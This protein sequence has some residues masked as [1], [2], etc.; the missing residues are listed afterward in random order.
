MLPISRFGRYG[1]L[2]PDD[3][4]NSQPFMSALRLLQEQGGLAPVQPSNVRNSSAFPSES[5]ASTPPPP[6]PSV[7]IGWAPTPS[8]R[9]SPTPSTFTEIPLEELEALRALIP[10]PTQDAFRITD[11]E[12]QEILD[13]IPNLSQ[14]EAAA[15]FRVLAGIPA[16]RIQSHFL[17]SVRTSVHGVLSSSDGGSTT[18]VQLPMEIDPSQGNLGNP[19]VITDSSQESQAI[20]A[21]IASSF[22]SP[23]DLP[24]SDALISAPALSQG[25][26]AHIASL[27][28]EGGDYEEV[29]S[30]HRAGQDGTPILPE[31]VRA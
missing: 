18:P 19:I 10:S 13:A 29:G 23:P 30:G 1:P 11:H 4:D 8:Q 20:D 24:I 3:P 15:M 14:E 22:V 26:R 6:S 21:R 16:N 25:T 31:T 17:E 27:L 7:V 12:L 2:G 5:A 9:E 28:T